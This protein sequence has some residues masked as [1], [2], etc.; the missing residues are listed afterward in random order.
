MLLACALSSIGCARRIQREMEV[1]DE[2]QLHKEDAIAAEFR[3]QALDSLAAL[4]LPEV[5]DLTVKHW[6]TTKYQ[7]T[8]LPVSITLPLQCEGHTYT[9]PAEGL[10]AG[11]DGEAVLVHNGD[12]A[13]VLKRARETKNNKG[14]QT[15]CDLMRKLQFAGVPNVAHCEAQCQV[16][17]RRLIVVEPYVPV[18]G[19]GIGSISEITVN[20]ERLSNEAAERAASLTFATAYA[21]LQVGVINFDQDHNILYAKDGTPTFIDFGRAEDLTTASLPWRKVRAKAFLDVI[22]GKAPLGWWKPSQLPSGESEL[23]V[24]TALR[25]APCPPTKNGP[26]TEQDR[27]AWAL[28]VESMI[29]AMLKVG[30]KQRW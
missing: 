7:W 13:V 15:E 29:A 6:N 17:D 20:G 28:L 12:R 4:V 27:N 18:S 24:V 3:R 23:P 26:A 16:H 10:G 21:M 1:L 22:V 11:Q 25:A 9:E 14:L 2:H 8:M 30:F 5:V 19:A